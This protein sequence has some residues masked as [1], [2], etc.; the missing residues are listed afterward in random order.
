MLKS[1]FSRFQ[2]CR[3]QYGSI[4]IRLAVG[5][6]QICEIPQNSPKIQTYKFKV[7]NLC[8][9]RKSLCNFLLVINGNS[10]GVSY[11]FRDIDTFSSKIACFP[12]PPLFDAPTGWAPCDINVIYT[13]LKSKFNGLH[14][15]HIF[16]RLFA[17]GS[18][19]C[20][21]LQNFFT[22]QKLEGWGYRKVKIS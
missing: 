20:E 2:R 15:C 6:S 10:G 3:W 7:I 21:I 16:I 22:P 11:H 8:V 18:Q 5:A 14:F 12:T 13:P 9:Y 17:V 4:F 19:M 1:T